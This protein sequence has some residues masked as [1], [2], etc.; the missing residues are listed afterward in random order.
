[1]PSLPVITD[2]VES[3]QHIIGYTFNDPRHAMEALVAPGNYIPGFINRMSGNKDL[4]Q[5]GESVLK[6]TLIL[7]GYEAGKSRESIDQ[8]IK[9]NSKNHLTAVGFNLGLDASVIVN[10]AQG[11]VVSTGVMAEAIQGIIG[12]VFID[13]GYSVET[14]RSLVAKLGLGWPA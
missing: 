1:M 2:R 10:P 8:E 5:L 9:A 14:V 3:L 11:R 6:M 12:A 13:S 7:D 4:A